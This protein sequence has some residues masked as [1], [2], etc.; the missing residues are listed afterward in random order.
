MR[1]QQVPSSG[2]GGSEHSDE[3]LYSVKLD[4]FEGPLDL[5][6]YLIKKDELDIYDIP[7]ARITGQYLEYLHLMETLDLEVA[8]EYLVVAATLMRIKSSMLIPRNPELEDEEDPREELVRAL[9]EYRKFKEVSLE[10]KSREEQ[11]RDIFGRSD[12]VAPARFTRSEFVNDF[13]LYDLMAAFKDVLDRATEDVFCEVAVDRVTVEDRVAFILTVLED[14]TGVRFA[15][16]FD[17]NPVR[18]VVVLTF[19]ALLE[20]MRTGKIGLRQ[21]NPFSDIWIYPAAA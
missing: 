12:L 1:L 5:L 19:V 14:S 8:G 2:N 6:L 13:T 4:V 7:I 11:T 9:L 3:T 15:D 17:D 16:L 18:T 20:L 10:L 21:N